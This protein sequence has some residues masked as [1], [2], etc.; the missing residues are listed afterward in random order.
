MNDINIYESESRR[1][2]IG[3]AQCVCLADGLA[4]TPGKYGERELDG[5]WKLCGS[6]ITRCSREIRSVHALFLFLFSMASRHPRDRR[7]M[8]TRRSFTPSRQFDESLD[9][10][11]EKVVLLKGIA[12]RIPL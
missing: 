7:S 2:R 8:I 11:A 1:K 5:P 6:V 9:C 10:V 3:F 4:E 12:G